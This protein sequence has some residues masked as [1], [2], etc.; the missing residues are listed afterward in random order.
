MADDIT[1]NISITTSDGTA[2]LATDYGTSGTGLSLAHVQLAKL[3]WGTDSTTNRV[4]ETNPLPIYLYGTTGS[5]LIGITGTI[6]GTGGAFPVRNTPNS[7]LIVGGPASGSTMTYQPVQVTGFVQGATNGILLGVTGTVRLNQN[8]NV[9]GV[10][11]GVLI[12]V[13][14]GRILSSATDS[15]TVVGT[16]GLSGGMALSAAS[17]SVAVWGSDLGGKVLTKLYAADGTTIGHSGDALNV[18]IVGAGITATIS[19]NPVVGVTNGYGLPLKV[20]GSGVT[21]DAAVIIQGKLAGGAVEIGAV[22]AVPVSITGA[23]EIDD[24]A[25]IDS[26]ESTSK[27]LVSN[28]I[29]IKNNTAVI[30]TINERL[31]NNIIQSKVTEIVKPAKMI[32]GTKD[33]TA[34]A[35]AISSTTTIKVGAHIK[36]PLTN[37]DTVYVGSSTLV[38]T[39]TS[40]FPLE[41]G[42]SLFIEIDN[43]NKI[44]ARS[45]STNQKIAYLAS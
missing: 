21:T 39:P 31:T 7:Y 14:G 4:S 12:G 9:H 5:A 11:N 35:A 30:S 2:I 13:T 16:V 34:N 26:L 42:E 32:N 38:T 28:L 45:D 24:T 10:T 19:I 17:N 29:S 23:V 41:P 3:A 25:L 20:C 18:N 8:L 36:A 37:T 15:V 44:Y 6:N 40:G 27:P 22:T 43:I 1:S 33:L